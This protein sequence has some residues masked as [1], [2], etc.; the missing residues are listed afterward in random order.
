MRGISRVP[1]PREPTRRATKQRKPILHPPNCTI[2][3]VQLTN[4]TPG[5]ARLEEER[6]TC[7]GGWV[8]WVGG[9]MHVSVT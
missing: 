5:P 3:R 8:G 6:D 2:P 1:V 4:R 7:S 9:W